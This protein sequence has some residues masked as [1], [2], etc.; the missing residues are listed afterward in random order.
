MGLFHIT[1]RRP[2]PARP[3]HGEA[4]T[5]ERG[6]S[7]AHRTR[8]LLATVVAGIGGLL[9]GLSRKAATE[10]SFFLAIPTMFMATGYDVY[11][12]WH[13]LAQ[14]D[15]A[16]FAVGFVT[17]FFSALL[18]IKALIRYVA[19]HNFRIFAWYRV[20]FGAIALVY[21]LR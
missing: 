20:I 21:F 7:C 3:N 15:L 11:K 1:R 6:S 14:Q 8:D 2:R 4:P 16:F 10:F 17:A 5:E 13:A 19:H 9:W 18:A 12:S